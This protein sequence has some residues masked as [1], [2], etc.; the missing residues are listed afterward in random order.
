MRFWNKV[1]VVLLVG[2]SLLGCKENSGTT[3]SVS[4]ESEIPENGA[5][6]LFALTAEGFNPVDTFAVNSSGQFELTKKVDS[7]GFYRVDVARQNFMNLVIE[8]TEDLI[9]IDLKKDGKE[10]SGSESAQIVNQIDQRAA[11]LQASS[12]TINQSGMQAMQEGDA[13]AVERL[14]AEFTTLQADFQNDI[15]ELIE[16]SSNVLASLYGLNYLDMD[17]EFEFFDKVVAEASAELGED[18]FWVVELR[19]NLEAIRNLAIGQP[20]PD[21]QLPNPDGEMIALSDL[22]GK[23]VL[24]DFWAAWC[25]PCRQENPIVVRAYNKYRNENFEILGVSLDRTRDAWIKAI[26]DDGLPWLHVS[27]LKYYDSEAAQLYNINFI[28]AT[29]LIGPDGTIVDKNLRGASL[30]NKLEEL[31]GES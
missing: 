21:F 6:V 13:I 19:T 11:E 3:I 2:G 22:R 27:D 18:H 15:K 12:N 9:D 24:I 1:G 28:P 16:D 8:G 10:V 5:V 26:D 17:A 4:V 31:F 30:D 23:Y 29:Y 14:R 20:A 7:V 25:R